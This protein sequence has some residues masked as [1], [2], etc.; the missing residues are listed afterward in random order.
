[1]VGGGGGVGFREAFK[2][3][4]TQRGEEH[5]SK[6]SEFRG[7]GRIVLRTKKSENVGFMRGKRKNSTPVTLE[8]AD[9]IGEKQGISDRK[10]ARTENAAREEEQA[11]VR[12]NA[13]LK[14]ERGRGT[15]VGLNNGGQGEK[16]PKERDWGTHEVLKNLMGK[17]FQVFRTKIR[18]R[19]NS[20]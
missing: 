1:M 20:G 18:Q 10:A 13:R 19:R 7:R 12:G 9:E 17:N 8:G 16:K 6:A 15:G 11:L 3:K 2:K 14:E 5:T 4:K